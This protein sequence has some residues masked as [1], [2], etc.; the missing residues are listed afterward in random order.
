MSE[1]QIGMGVVQF[2]WQSCLCHL[3]PH[4]Y[5]K[6]SPFILMVHSYAPVCMGWRWWEDLT[7]IGRSNLGFYQIKICSTFYCHNTYFRK[8]WFDPWG[9]EMKTFWNKIKRRIKNETMKTEIMGDNRNWH[10]PKF[11][12]PGQL[13]ETSLQHTSWESPS[14]RSLYCTLCIFKRPN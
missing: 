1:I 10:F 3:G 11:S 9:P 12:S 8:S 4:S 5:S 7:L 6:H 13:R 14:N 2:I